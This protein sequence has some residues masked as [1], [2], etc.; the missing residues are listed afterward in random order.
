M[1]SS[2]IIPLAKFQSVHDRAIPIA[3][4]TA[5]NIATKEVVCTHS[6]HIAA[7]IINAFN[8][9]DTN[10]SINLSI[11]GSIFFASIVLFIA[12]ISM[13]TTLNH[14]HIVSI[15][16]TIFG[17]YHILKSIA[18]SAYIFMFFMFILFN[19]HVIFFCYGIKYL[20]TLF[21]FSFL[22]IFVIFCLL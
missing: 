7:I 9:F 15:A 8:M 21:I 4:P 11:V 22:S 12:F 1:K 19:S 6:I 17:A 5:A 3:K 2:I 10:E 14:I 20:C 13:F 16:H 18:F